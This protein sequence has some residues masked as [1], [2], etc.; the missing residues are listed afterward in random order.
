MEKVRAAKRFTV[1]MSIPGT[2]RYCNRYDTRHLTIRK[3]VHSQVVWFQSDSI[4]GT[5]LR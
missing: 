3:T 4:F 1:M 2:P 5:R